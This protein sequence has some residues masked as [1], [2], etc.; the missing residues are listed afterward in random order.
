MNCDTVLL[1]VRYIK[2]LTIETERAIKFLDTKIQDERRI[3]AE[4]KT[5]ISNKPNQK[6]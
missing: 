2:N 1:G 4:I 6:S 3:L 5:K